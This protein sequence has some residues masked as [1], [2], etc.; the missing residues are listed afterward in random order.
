MK[1]IAIA[2]CLLFAACLPAA[3]HTLFLDVAGK[4]VE[5]E[6]SGPPVN[7]VLEDGRQVA[8]W[9]AEDAA[10]IARTLAARDLAW[11]IPGA[12]G[13]L[14]VADKTPNCVSLDVDGYGVASV[15]IPGKIAKTSTGRVVWTEAQIEAIQTRLHDIGREDALP[16]IFG[17]TLHTQTAEELATVAPQGD[18]V[19]TPGCGE[20]LTG[21]ACVYNG[22]SSCCA[23]SG[24]T[25][26][27]CK[28]CAPKRGGGGTF[29]PEL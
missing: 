22:V 25:C 28:T 6:T 8:T 5:V 29:E 14:K 16:A 12:L 23:G 4:Q 17:L 26:T 24:G 19:L 1:R 11:A 9:K 10:A 3:A 20:C 18:T 21:Q 15:P 2:L 27:A 13:G 7:A